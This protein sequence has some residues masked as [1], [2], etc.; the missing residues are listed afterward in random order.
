[1]HSPHQSARG[2]SAFLLT[3]LGC[4]HS[5]CLQYSSSVG[6]SSS[7]TS[8]ISGILTSSCA[9]VTSS[10]LKPPLTATPVLRTRHVGQLHLSSP[11]TVTAAADSPLTPASR[12]CPSVPDPAVGPL[13]AP[14]SSSSGAVSSWW[15][16]STAAACPVQLGVGWN[17]TSQSA[18]RRALRSFGTLRPQPEQASVRTRRARRQSRSSIA[19]AGCL[20]GSSSWGLPCSGEQLRQ[21]HD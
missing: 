11:P 5:T 16:A 14:T 1:M 10:C 12:A 19:A 8:L 9:S 4:R 21:H 20:S 17:T 18:H 13:D 15:V 6:R 7:S 2:S 3:A